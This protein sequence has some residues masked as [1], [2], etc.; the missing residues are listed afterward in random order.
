[1][2]YRNLYEVGEADEARGNLVVYLADDVFCAR[3]CVDLAMSCIPYLR[4]NRIVC[5]V[6]GHDDLMGLLDSEPRTG[7]ARYDQWHL[8]PR[9]GYCRWRQAM[10][11]ASI[12][13][14]IT[15]HRNA[16]PVDSQT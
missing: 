16:E 6:R 12:Q 13:D 5:P 1:M 14:M 4:R 3:C 10:T 2:H 9:A 8:L 11:K 7:V 15:I